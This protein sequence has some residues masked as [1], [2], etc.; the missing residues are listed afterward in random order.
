MIYTVG[1]ARKRVKNAIKVTYI[2]VGN[3]VEKK[4]QLNNIYIQY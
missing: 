2:W 4:Y 1:V 3:C